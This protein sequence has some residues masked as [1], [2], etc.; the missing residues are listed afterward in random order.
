MA[1]VL[2][3]FAGRLQPGDRQRQKQDLTTGNT[4]EFTEERH[5]ALTKTVLVVRVLILGLYSQ[6]FVLAIRAASTRFAA[7]NLL[8]ASDR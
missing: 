4:E 2:C 1:F 5:R 7:P 8:I 3:D 6:P